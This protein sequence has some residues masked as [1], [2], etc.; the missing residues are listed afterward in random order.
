MLLRRLLYPMLLAPATDEGALAAISAAIEN[1]EGEASNA[2]SGDPGGESAD[3]EAAG[4][5]G[6]AA[7]P[8][9]RAGTQ[10]GEPE[11]DAG[12]GAGGEPSAEEADAAAKGGKKGAAAD[13]SADSEGDRG[14]GRNAAGRFVKKQGETD[15]QLATRR[16]ADP[17]DGKKPGA[18]PDPAAKKADHVNDPIPPEIKGRTRE[19][20]EGLVATTKELNTK[21]EAQAAELESGRELFGMIEATGANA[22]TFA[23]HM[24]VLALMTS[25]DPGEQQQA[26]TFLRAAADKIGQ[27]LGETPT[28]KDPLEGHADLLEEVDGG[29]LTRKRAE[30]IAKQRNATAATDRRRTENDSRNTEADAAAQARAKVKTA[31]NDLSTELAKK[32]GAEVYARKHKLLVPMIKRLNAA[33]PPD[34]IVA[35]VREAY[36]A[37][38]LGPAAAAPANGQGRAPAGTGGRQPARATQGAGAGGPKTP[39]SALEAL[40]FGLEEHARATGAR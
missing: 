3:G 40:E 24:D 15:E 14:D 38:E 12:K 23:R 20:M 9:E 19:R 35:A 1:P 16:S 8:G 18:A 39:T 28:G 6:G 13:P 31:L 36:A 4:G 5:E 7:G 25:Q 32:D 27:Q 17:Q 10:G 29:E 21:L 30:E 33:L 37:I 34:K 2:A 11:P 22:E 26:V